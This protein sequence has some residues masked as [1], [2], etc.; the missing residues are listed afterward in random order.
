MEEDWFQPRSDLTL[1][2][3]IQSRFPGIG[4]FRCKSDCHEGPYHIGFVVP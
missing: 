3:A 2:G 1:R 4:Y